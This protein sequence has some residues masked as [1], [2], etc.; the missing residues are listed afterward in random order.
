M[1]W[2]EKMSDFKYDG[3][4]SGYT[5]EAYNWTDI[6]PEWNDTVT[7]IIDDGE[8]D[9]LAIAISRDVATRL[10]K[11]LLNEPAESQI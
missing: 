1:M 6:N 11:W 3:N 7:I 10:G 4:V 8:F 2:R 9:S 5:I